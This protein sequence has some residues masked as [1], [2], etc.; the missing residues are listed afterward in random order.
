MRALG[1]VP[2]VSAES[3]QPWGM[4]TMLYFV[5]ILFSC[6]C[7]AVMACIQLIL[8]HLEILLH[9]IVWFLEVTEAFSSTFLCLS[10]GTVCE[11]EMFLPTLITVFVVFR[12]SIA[13]FELPERTLSKLSPIK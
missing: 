4:L 3:G 13:Y 1:V 5:H 11:G 2:A 9:F 6:F 10:L 8:T 7:R 12:D